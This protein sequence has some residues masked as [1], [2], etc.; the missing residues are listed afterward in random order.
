MTMIIFI[1]INNKIW[2]I[3][4]W[5]WRQKCSVPHPHA[6]IRP[7]LVPTGMFPV[8][9]LRAKPILRFGV[10]A[11]VFV[12]FPVLPDGVCG[13]DVLCGARDLLL[14]TAGGGGSWPGKA[15]VCWI[16]NSARGF[17]LEVFFESALLPVMS[18]ECVVDALWA[19]GLQISCESLVSLLQV[20]LFQ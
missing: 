1:V 11:V 19:P 12:Q 16:C 3:R 18:V 7:P 14:R 6:E 10:R 17:G 20:F 4:G 8:C 2:K 9:E 15:G 13:V 5:N